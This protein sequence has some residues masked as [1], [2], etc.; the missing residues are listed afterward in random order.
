VDIFAVELTE[1]QYTV[2]THFLDKQIGKPYDFRGVAS[3]VLRRNVGRDG[4]WFCSEY[5]QAA[6]AAGG[7]MFLRCPPFK[8]TPTMLYYSTA[9][10]FVRTEYTTKDKT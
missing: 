3:F 6:F 1:D 10:R 5:Q 9:Q 2:I 4:A 7:H 8:A